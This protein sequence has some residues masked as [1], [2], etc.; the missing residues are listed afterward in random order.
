MRFRLAPNLSTLERPKRPI[1]EVNKNSGAHQ[2]NFNEDRPI[3]LVGKC[4]PMHLFAISVNADMRR[5]S[6]REG[7]QKYICHL[8]LRLCLYMYSVTV[9]VLIFLLIFLRRHSVSGPTPAFSAGPPAHGHSH[10]QRETA[11]CAPAQPSRLLLW[12]D[13]WVD[14]VVRTSKQKYADGYLNV[15]DRQTDGH[16]TYCRITALC[17]NIAR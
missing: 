8:Y 13:P 2:K 3:S 15:T 17:A 10:N 1:A 11:G 6:I 12:V 14:R 7:R 5:G 4:R 16:T 9:L